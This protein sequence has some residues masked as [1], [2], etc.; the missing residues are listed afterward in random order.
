MARATVSRLLERSPLRAPAFRKFYVGATT[1][2]TGYTMQATIAAWLMATITPS[3]V[4]VALVQTA[5]TAPAIVFGLIAGSLADVVDRRKIIGATIIVMVAACALLA[6]TAATASIGPAGLLALTFL[7][8]AG[9][10]VYM[11]AQASSVNDFVVRAELPRAIALSAA[12]FNIARAIGPALAGAIAAWF[13]I[14]AALALAALLF[15]P[16][17]VPLRVWPS[18]E[19]P[20]PGIPEKISSGVI[21]GLRYARHSGALRALLFRTFS[22]SVCASAFWALLPVIARD[23][24]GVGAGGFGLLSAAFGCGAIL[25]ALAL[26]RMLQRY[27]LDGTVTRAGYL[28][29]GAIGLIALFDAH[30]L[31]VLG[32]FAAGL[33]WVSSFAAISTGVQGAAPAWVRSRAVAMN[34][35]AM[36]L[37][38]AVG[39]ALWGAIAAAST[40]DS[41][42]TVSALLALLLQLIN[43]RVPIAPGTEAEVTTGVQLPELAI[44]TEPQH[45]D[46]PILVQLTYHVERERRDAFQRV[47]QRMEPIRRRNG[48]TSWRVFRDLEQ[49]GDFVE[50]F[51]ISS[52]AEYMR[53]RARMTQAERE[54]QTDV[55]RLQSANRPV[56]ISRFIGIDPTD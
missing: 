55:E 16:M 28:W 15:V 52:Y 31:V 47:I 9:F 6:V 12:S 33:A 8:G 50:R 44:V 19:R 17:A 34:L 26:P 32:A 14:W 23:N 38:I 46:G 20:L 42:L 7:I 4:M 53:S 1:V 56:R 21:I 13:D 2:A 49:D 18:R 22:F 24:L 45:D 3:T 29:A 41:A 37:V 30:A 27:S 39:S 25:G 36:Q 43:R 11:P 5:S 48:A 54:V 10:S 35:V 51:I 40:T